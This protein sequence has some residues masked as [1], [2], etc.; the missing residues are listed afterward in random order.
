MAAFPESFV[1]FS[2][3]AN[4]LMA[5]KSVIFK[6]TLVAIL[7]VPAFPKHNGNPGPGGDGDG[8]FEL[9]NWL[10][11]VDPDGNKINAYFVTVDPERDT[12]E[13]LAQY[14]PAFDKRFVGLYGDAAATEAAFA[15]VAH[16]LDAELG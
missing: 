1:T 12:Q 2:L 10:S 5:S 3:K 15:R 9:N 16:H 11:K 13:V 7:P 14:V 8:G 6:F 4:A